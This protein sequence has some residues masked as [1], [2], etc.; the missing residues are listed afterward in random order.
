MQKDFE[1]RHS[2]DKQIQEAKSRSK[3]SRVKRCLS[4]TEKVGPEVE[5]HPLCKSPK[6]RFV[7]KIDKVDAA[8]NAV[9]KKIGN[10]L[11]VIKK[12]EDEKTFRKS[13]SKKVKKIAGVM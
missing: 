6:I 12:L 3:P 5:E 9:N 11:W 7:N 10:T 4:F 2:V 13:L 1:V 8:L